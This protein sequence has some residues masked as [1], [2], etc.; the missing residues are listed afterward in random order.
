MKY[1][2]SEFADDAVIGSANTKKVDVIIQT[3]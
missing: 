1:S 2:R 3:E